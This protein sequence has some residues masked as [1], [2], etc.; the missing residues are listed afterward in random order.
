MCHKKTLLAYNQL[1]LRLGL[2]SQMA[3]LINV[4]ILGESMVHCH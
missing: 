3:W 2:A 1:E 4:S